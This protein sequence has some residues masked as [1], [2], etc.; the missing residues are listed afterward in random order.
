MKKMLTAAVCMLMCLLFTACGA[1]APIGGG[2][3]YLKGQERAAFERDLLDSLTV[4]D[5]GGSY[6]SYR[7][8]FN[9]SSR[10]DI[11]DLWLRS[12]DYANVF[13]RCPYVPKKTSAD[14]QIYMRSDMALEDISFVLEYSIGDFSYS[15]GGV[16]LDSAQAYS[17]I[18]ITLETSDGDVKLD[19]FG[20][21]DLSGKKIRRLDAFQ[22]VSIA[23]EA[24]FSGDSGPY[25]F[26]SF[27]CQTK[28]P[29][30]NTENVFYRL[31]DEDG[32]IHDISR[33]YCTKGSSSFSISLDTELRPGSYTLEFDE[34][35]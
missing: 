35:E 15:R 10:Y 2:T 17:D 14:F 22:I 30:G 13:L 4:A 16:R 8:S 11:M 12:K 5:C 1:I 27:E 31:I 7:V 34:K 32:V 33:L 25:S 29:L 19:P 26:V 18:S 24:S 21:V 20:T 28:E 9:N 3:P 23:C 6:G